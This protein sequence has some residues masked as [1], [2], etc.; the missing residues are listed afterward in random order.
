MLKR[1][2]L[3]LMGILICANDMGGKPD[4]NLAE[5]LVMEAERVTYFIRTYPSQISPDYIGGILSTHDAFIHFDILFI[6]N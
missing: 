6:S 4:G 3:N 1:D 5:C 2:K